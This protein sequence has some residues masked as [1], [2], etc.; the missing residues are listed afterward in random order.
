VAGLYRTIEEKRHL[1]SRNGVIQAY[2][3]LNYADEWKAGHSKLTPQLIL[4]LQRLAVNQIY[5]CAGNFRDGPV[6]LEDPETNRTLHRPPIHT[7]VS[8]LVEQ[9]CDYV[10]THWE[11]TPLHL[12]SYLMWR[13]NWI[14]PFFGGNGRTARAVSYLILCARLGF[15]LP[16]IK[17]IPD[18]IVENRGPYYGALRAADKA[19]EKGAI[20]VK[21][22]EQLTGDL[23]ATQLVGV[24]DMATGQKNR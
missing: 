4:E 8:G 9:M 12:A 14:H 6:V 20:D 21:Q 16:G 10:Q 17:T 18:L 13:L 7:E 23:L 1:E 3:V 24:L 19:W 5:I 15:R 2:A 11:A 22:M